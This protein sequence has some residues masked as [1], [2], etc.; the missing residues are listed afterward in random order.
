[1]SA[2]VYRRGWRPQRVRRWIGTFSGVFP[3]I[4]GYYAISPAGQTRSHAQE[5]DYASSAAGRTGSSADQGDYD[6]PR[7]GGQPT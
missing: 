5:G 6:A 1:M 2:P 4:T 7:P 3:P